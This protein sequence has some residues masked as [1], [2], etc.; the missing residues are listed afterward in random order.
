MKLKLSYILITTLILSSCGNNSSKDQKGLACKLTTPELRKRKET[1]IASLKK[2]VIE[3]KELDKGFAYKF[4]SSDSINK[5]LAEFM[6]SEKECC[7]FFDL[8]LSDT[9]DKSAKWLEITGPMGTKEFI[10]TELEL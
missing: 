6:N 3:T 10:K 8:K 4:N 7:N 2:Q 5:E 1:V 9:E